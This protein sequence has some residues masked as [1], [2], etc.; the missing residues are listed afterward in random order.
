MASAE[1]M[2]FR[3]RQVPRVAAVYSLKLVECIQQTL[4]VVFG[5]AMH[6][7]DVQRSQRYT[8]EYTRRH[9]YDDELDFVRDQHAKRVN[10]ACASHS[11]LESRGPTPRTLERA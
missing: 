2:R 10:E 4:Y 11:V 9:A 8:V 3:R 1:K 5:S 6:D 7:V